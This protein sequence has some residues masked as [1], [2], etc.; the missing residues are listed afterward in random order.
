MITNEGAAIMETLPSQQRRRKRRHPSTVNSPMHEDDNEYNV[1]RSR[2]AVWG[3]AAL[4][5]V[6][7]VSTVY[8]SYSGMSTSLP[9]G[10][11]R[12]RE[13]ALKSRNLAHQEA[14]EWSR[15][16]E[17]F[18]GPDGSNQIRN[19][20]LMRN[21]AS[22]TTTRIAGGN[23]AANGEY[24]FFVNSVPPNFCGGTL[25]HSDI[26][27]TAAQCADA[28]L[29][30]ANVGGTL[31]DGSDGEAIDVESVVYQHPAYNAETGENNIMLVKLS[32]NSSAPVVTLNFDA[33][34]PLDGEVVTVIGYGD[35]GDGNVSD[36]LLEAEVDVY[37]NDSCGI[38]ES[39]LCAGT[40][41]GGRDRCDQD[42]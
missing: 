2:A 10:R 33:A 41:A 34:V 3:W 18:N 30:G 12:K 5:V 31:L 28:F 42:T 21:R 6:V 17:F 27:L 40:E 24:P 39:Q 1:E 11:E 36:T 20:F 19:I 16:R 26:V 9:S 38:P 15:I 4:A 13:N 32:G 35:T 14:D 23:G 7:F 22:Q 25:I 8:A 29:G 37:S